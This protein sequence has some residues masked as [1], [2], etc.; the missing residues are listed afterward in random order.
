VLVK[1]DTNINRVYV[2]EVFLKGKT[3]CPQSGAVTDVAT[4]GKRANK[5]NGAVATVLRELYAVNPKGATAKSEVVNT[6]PQ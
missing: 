4:S 2:H 1:S 5:G 6:L 3:P